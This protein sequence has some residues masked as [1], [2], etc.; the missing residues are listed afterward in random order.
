MI[1]KDPEKPKISDAMAKGDEPMRSFGDL[2]QMFSKE[3]GQTTPSADKKPAA[4]PPAA[5]KPVA[6][7]PA[8]VKPADTA[9]ADAP[10]AE[11]P[12]AEASKPAAS[13][14]DE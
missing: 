4:K 1:G 12:V 13:E 7:K 3:K 14:G 11:A 9:P 5:E 2:M 6:E 10:K 8:E